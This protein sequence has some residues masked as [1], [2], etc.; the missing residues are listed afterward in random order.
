MDQNLLNRPATA[1]I[2]NP[3]TMKERTF[4]LCSTVGLMSKA[5]AASEAGYKSPPTAKRIRMAVNV[6]QDMMM[7]E[8][9][10]T[11]EDVKHGI[12]EAINIGRAKQEGMTMLAGWRDMAKILGLID[13]G[14]KG[15][16]VNLTQINI[17]DMSELSI[18]QL[19][20]LAEPVLKRTPTGA[21]ILEHENQ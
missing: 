2:L 8:L 3:L 11:K 13:S 4:V 16:D 20:A 6:L 19:R 14:P 15:G 18:D 21:A 12:L 7:E 9:S 5:E 1:A 10:I 17:K